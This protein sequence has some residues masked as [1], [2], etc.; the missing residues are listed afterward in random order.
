MNLLLETDIFCTVSPEED[1]CTDVSLGPAYRPPEHTRE[2]HGISGTLSQNHGGQ[3][4]VND[5]VTGPASGVEF[6]LTR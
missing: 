1:T 2:Y 4:T 5:T 6:P 3:H